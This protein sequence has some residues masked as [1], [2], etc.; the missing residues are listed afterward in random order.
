MNPMAHPYLSHSNIKKNDL[1]KTCLIGRDSTVQRPTAN[2]RPGYPLIITL[3][4]RN[5]PKT[6]QKDKGKPLAQWTSPKKK[7]T[8]KPVNTKLTIQH[9]FKECL[10]DNKTH[11]DDHTI[12]S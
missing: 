2:R 6:M 3:Q 11:D 9:N 7:H 12:H 5:Q 8:K 10:P 1:I 4:D